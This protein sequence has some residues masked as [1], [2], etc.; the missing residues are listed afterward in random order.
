M[1]QTHVTIP[2]GS[3]LPSAFGEAFPPVAGWVQAVGELTHIELRVAG[4]PSESRRALT[5]RYTLAQL[6]G[7]LGGPYG[8]VLTRAKGEGFELIAGLLV[9]AKVVSLAAALIEARPGTTLRSAAAAVAPAAARAGEP[10]WAAQ[11]TA[12]ARA[13]ERARVDE[14]DSEEEWLPER[15][16]LVQ[17]FAFGVGEVLSADGDRLTTRDLAGTGRVRELRTSHLLIGAPTVQDGKRLFVLA[18]RK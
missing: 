15:G 10:N 12:Q 18:R 14:R 3:E 13:I 11:A 8:V 5:Q 17:H 16:D 6:G 1:T 9:R 4:E 2:E 7:P